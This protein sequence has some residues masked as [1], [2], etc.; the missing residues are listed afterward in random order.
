MN[1]TINEQKIKQEDKHTGKGK[2]A[3]LDFQE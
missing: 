2:T 3:D 1:G